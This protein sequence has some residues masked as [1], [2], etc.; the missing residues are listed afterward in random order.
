MMD[1]A[2]AFEKTIEIA[3]SGILREEECDGEEV[4]LQQRAVQIEAV[5]TVEDFFVN[6]DPLTAELR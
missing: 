1:L 5:D 3:R 4:L 6:N 2:D